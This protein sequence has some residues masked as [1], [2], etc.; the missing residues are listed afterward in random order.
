MSIDGHY[1]ASD[2]SYSGSE[3]TY[4][5]IHSNSSGDDPFYSGIFTLAV[6][7][8]NSL[9]STSGYLDASLGANAWADSYAYTYVS[10]VPEPETYAMMLAGLGLVG[11]M[12]RRRTS[13]SA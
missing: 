9:L 3:S 12:A 8:S 5:R 13:K 1:S 6:A 4:K 2:G 10:G 11:T 7:N